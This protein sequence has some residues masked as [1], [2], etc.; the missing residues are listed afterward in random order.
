MNAGGVEEERY[1]ERASEQEVKYLHPN[2]L[3]HEPKPS[4]TKNT[5]FTNGFATITEH[6]HAHRYGCHFRVQELVVR[7]FPSLCFY[8]SL[9]I[10]SIRVHAN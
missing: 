9:A 1:R 5:H 3:E 8:L 4:M 2:H 6:F 7:F 10:H